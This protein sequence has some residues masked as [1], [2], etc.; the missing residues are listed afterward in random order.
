[1]R[2]AAASRVR[3]VGVLENP[4]MPSHQ[5]R[6]ARTKPLH[7]HRAAGGALVR[8]LGAL[9]LLLVVVWAA[10]SVGAGSLRPAEVQRRILDLPKNAVFEGAMVTGRVT[11]SGDP[12]LAAHFPCSADEAVA[13]RPIVLVH[14]TPDTMGAWWPL[15]FGPGALAGTAD[16][17]T[18]EVVGHGML[19]DAEG[20]FSFQR[21]A[22][23]VA[24]SLDSLELSGVTLVD[25]PAAVRDVGTPVAL[26]L[27]RWRARVPG[28][29]PERNYDPQPSNLKR[30]KLSAQSIGNAGRSDVWHQGIYM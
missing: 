5:I 15:L 26:L 17:W 3:G 25:A 14:G 20:P 9:L 10:I 16:V 30:Q 6:T 2:R 4:G 21:C 11:A 27:R 8:L 29:A 13:R 1:M 28:E 18:L 24:G 19:G 7:L 23:H 12:V 22:D